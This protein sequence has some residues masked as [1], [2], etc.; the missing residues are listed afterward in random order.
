MCSPSSFPSSSS[1]VAPLFQNQSC[2]PFT[3]RN[4][5]CTLG[6]YVDYA[7]NVSSAADVAAGLKFAQAHNIRMVIKNTGHDLLGKSTGKGALGIWTH[8][9]K[10]IKFLDY[11]SAAYS[12]PAIK[13]GAG[14]QGWELLEAAQA[15]GLR[16]VG[17]ACPT[18]G[19]A[20]GYS[21]GGGH[22][23]LSSVYGLG[24]DNVLEW[25]VV[26]ADGEH[27]TASPTSYP[28]LYWALTGGGPGT[29]AVVVS[30]T[31]KAHQDNG[32]TATALSFSPTNSTEDIYWRAVEA[33][34]AILPTWVDRGG[35]AAYIILDK[36]FFL[37]PIVFPGLSKQ[38]VTSLVQ[39]LIDTLDG[40]N[41]TYNVNTTS[42]TQ[43]RDF[44]DNYFGP[45]PYGIFP[46]VQVQGG[47]LIP[48]SIVQTNNTG[49][50]QTLREIAAGGTFH[51]LGSGLNVAHSVA[52]NKPLSNSVL[53][54]WRDTIIHLVVRAEWDFTLPQAQNEANETEI[55][56][57]L[58][59]M[60]ET[61]SP[62]SGAYMNEGDP[63]QPN[64]QTVYYGS[65][66]E[67]L[68]A[69]KK[70]YDP[71]DLFYATAAVGSEAWTVAPNGGLCRSG[72]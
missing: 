57:R 36:F 62:G 64:W 71:N 28:D 22:S 21:Q 63:N 60:L 41:I 24:S 50:T 51:L 47:H 70:K 13:M 58:V 69:I 66:Y 23:L 33:F 7:I 43:Y 61:L 53:P 52:G 34:H 30:M 14:A 45:L 67:A 38:E 17:G 18:V 42:F 31:A 20:G 2:D 4:S 55:T 59:P 37:Q 44:Y 11:T 5:P 68:R 48:R 15:Q 72:R 65:N 32:V 3:P 29:Y 10:S 16:V 9:L 26:T 56:E 19:V 1:F 46:S 27:V 39:P 8:H 49:L 25:E 12:G 35:F 6:N 40:L 54:N